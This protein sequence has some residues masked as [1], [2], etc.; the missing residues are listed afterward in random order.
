MLMACR[1]YISDSGVD[2]SSR[3]PFRVQTGR[4]AGRQAGRQTK[5]QM[6]LLSAHLIQKQNTDKRQLLASNQI[7]MDNLLNGSLLKQRNQWTHARY[8]N[9]NL[10]SQQY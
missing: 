10:Y 8:V 6:P 3:F 2:S 5:S 4:Q 1:G 7:A 9:V